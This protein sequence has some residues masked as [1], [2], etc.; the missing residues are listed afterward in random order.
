MMKD[1]FYKKVTRNSLIEGNI[2]KGSINYGN[3]TP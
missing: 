3:T 2:S 1:K